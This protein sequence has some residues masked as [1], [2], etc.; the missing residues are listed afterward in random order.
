MLSQTRKAVVSLV[1]TGIVVLLACGCG[2][3]SSGANEALYKRMQ[4]SPVY[5]PSPSPET[6]QWSRKTG[7]LWYDRA[8]AAS[9]RMASTLVENDFKLVVRA[10]MSSPYGSLE[11]F[12]FILNADEAFSLKIRQKTSRAAQDSL[13]IELRSLPMETAH[14]AA[15]TLLQMNILHMRDLGSP[16]YTRAGATFTTAHVQHLVS[17]AAPGESNQF[18]CEGFVWA[19]DDRHDLQ[20]SKAGLQHLKVTDPY[21]RVIRCLEQVCE[22]GTSDTGE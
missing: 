15:D 14:L 11:E 7:D 17:A 3:G 2:P 13:T 10:E 6:G 22:S 4:W 1:L 18:Q 20:D 12:W 16:E 8:R 5:P 21:V 9:D 19:D